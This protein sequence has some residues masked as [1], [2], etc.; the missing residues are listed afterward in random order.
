M[1]YS[2]VIKKTQTENYTPLIFLK[3]QVEED[4]NKWRNI[5]CSWIGRF[6]TVKWQFFYSWPINMWPQSKHYQPIL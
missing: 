3:K 5:L 4:L 6:N 1:R 2:Y